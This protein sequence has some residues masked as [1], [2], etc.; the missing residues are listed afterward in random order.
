MFEQISGYCG[1]ATLTHKI[2]HHNLPFFPAKMISWRHR[3]TLGW[4][5]TFHI[6]S[7]SGTKFLHKTTQ[8]GAERGHWAV[9]LVSSVVTTCVALR[10]Y[11]V[12]PVRGF[13]LQD[14][15]I[16]RELVVFL[17]RPVTQW[18]PQES[19]SSQKVLTQLLEDSGRWERCLLGIKAK[20]FI[21]GL[22]QGPKSESELGIRW[23]LRLW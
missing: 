16:S 4:A 6:I 21:T 15:K 13:L 12:P 9:R 23:V 22:E 8:Q 11:K 19:Q 14:S 20:L 1:S 10:K 7:H 18:M 3:Q 2:D 17:Q 5:G